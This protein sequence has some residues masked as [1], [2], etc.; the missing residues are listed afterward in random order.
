MKYNIISFVVLFLMSFETN[1]Q[2]VTDIDGNSYNS[3]TIG[4]QTWM[5][6]NL[7]TTRF[8]NGVAI[9]TTFLSVNN[10]TNAL[11]QW[12]YDDDTSNIKTYG[13]LYTWLVAISNDNICPMGWRVPDQS[14]WDTL[15]N[16]L[17]GDSIA[18]GKMKESGTTHW[19][20]SDS[21]VTNSSG[22]TG[23]GGGFRG[24]PS[25]FNRIDEIGV[26]WSSTGFDAGSFPRGIGFRLNSTDNALVQSIAVGQNGASIRCL[27]NKSLGNDKVPFKSKI[28]IFPNPAIDKVYI[29][30]Q[31]S[32][33]Y[34]LSI[35]DMAGNML[36][37]Q[38]IAHKM[39]Y[40]DIDFLPKGNY[41]IKLVSEQQIVTYT[42]IKQ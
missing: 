6:E 24:N 36:Y 35:Y 21:T 39:N 33:K 26:F 10:D 7:R 16:F 37:E 11:Y 9:P 15:R 34:Q 38:R 41:L 2:T 17:G 25:G 27:L 32:I 22:F 42:L 40:V 1:A 5:Q 14:D 8:N 13:R 18:G 3:V 31:E 23:L 19:V 12:A 20:V 28:Q 29:N 30:L 4:S